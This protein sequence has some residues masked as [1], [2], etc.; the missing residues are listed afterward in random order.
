LL[1]LCCMPILHTLISHLA[2]ILNGE[3]GSAQTLARDVA[4]T[5]NSQ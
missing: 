3:K 5:A 4:A 1:S 2:T